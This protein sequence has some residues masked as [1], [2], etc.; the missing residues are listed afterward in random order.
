MEAVKK[1]NPFLWIARYFREAK[2]EL[3]KVAWPSRRDTLRYTALVIGV[4]VG[5]AAAIAGVD[6]SLARGLEALVSH[7]AK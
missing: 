3:E 2:E 6:W 7:V 1:A 5:L 4:S